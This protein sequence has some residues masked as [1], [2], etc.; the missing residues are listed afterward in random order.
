MSKSNFFSLQNAV[1]KVSVG[2]GGEEGVENLTEAFKLFSQETV[3]LE[4]AY[5]EL[6]GRLE[7]VNLELEESNKKLNQKLVELDAV[8]TYLESILG[9][10]TQ[11]IIFVGIA[12]FV[13]TFNGAAEKILG[14]NKEKVLFC[15]FWENFDDNAFGF[16]MREKFISKVDS[17]SIVVTRSFESG[18]C[19]EIEITPTFVDQGP[20]SNRGIIIL[21][22][23]I[24]EVRRLQRVA[25]RC[26]RLKELGEMAASVAHE[27]RNPLGGIEG[28]ASLLFRDLEGQVEKQEMASQIIS[29]TRELN[30]LVSKVLNYSRPVDLCCEYVDLSPFLEGVMHFLN[31]DRRLS[32]KV[33]FL[34]KKECE[35]LS[36][37]IDPL[38]FRSALFNLML[39]AAQA[40]EDGGDVLIFL[41][42]VNKHAVIEISDTGVGI[43]SENLEKI[44]SPFFTTKHNGNGFGLS[45]V[46]KVVQAHDA[47]LEVFSKPGKG[48]TFI[49][50]LLCE[51]R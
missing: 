15:N 18:E 9:H 22:R 26:D 31:V 13:T 24:S 4:K 44:F 33:H 43:P 38:M 35:L 45:E 49:I 12:G 29:G 8:S 46:Y 34:F 14:M 7:N 50:K 23:D 2:G 48:T 11:G 16:S 19:K 30:S 27:I 36:V 51:N 39:N 42:R 3:R 25:N 20:E 41:R 10:M 6:K 28:F 32:E 21:L 5:N 1:E 37:F 47:I 40:M 17:R